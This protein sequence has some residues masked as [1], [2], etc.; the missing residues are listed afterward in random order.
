MVR[1][2]SS[3]G[4]FENTA[5]ATVEKEESFTETTIHLP[6]KI[7]IGS[8]MR[9]IMLVLVISP[10]LFMMLRKNTLESVSKKITTFYDDN[11][12]CSNECNCND[13]LAEL[14]APKENV[15]DKNN[16]L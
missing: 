1:T 15:I 16:K 11:F 14:K 10:W 12:S 8:L 13:I 7:S 3:N 5:V 6:K 4:R 9:I 2:R